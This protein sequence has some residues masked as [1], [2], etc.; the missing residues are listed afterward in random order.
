M[1]VGRMEANKVSDLV[2][3][4]QS[5]EDVNSTNEVFKLLLSEPNAVNRQLDWL[6]YTQTLALK[7]ER[8]IMSCREHLLLTQKT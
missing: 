4:I 6:H 8:E 3:I 7:L 2:T 5:I 1:A